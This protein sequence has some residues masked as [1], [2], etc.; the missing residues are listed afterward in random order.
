MPLTH[1]SFPP[2]YFSPPPRTIKKPSAPLFPPPTSTPICYLLRSGGGRKD[3]GRTS[4]PPFR[5]SP[6]RQKQSHFGMGLRSGPP[7]L[8]HF[9]ASIQGGDNDRDHHGNTCKRPRNEEAM[10]RR[11]RNF[12]SPAMFPKAAALLLLLAAAAAIGPRE[13]E[14]KALAQT[15]VIG[16]K[17]FYCFSNSKCFPLSLGQFSP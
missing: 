10:R 15:Q 16:I 2:L 3:G 12:A 8:G 5:V 1:H 13:A 6:P 9:A 11:K 14:G 4:S 17:C 7:L